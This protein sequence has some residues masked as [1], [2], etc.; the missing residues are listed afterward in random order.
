MGAYEWGIEEI[1]PARADSGGRITQRVVQG[2]TYNYSY[3][4]QGQ[5]ASYTDVE[6]PRKSA[7]YTYDHADRRIAMTVGGGAAD[8]IA[9][10]YA[11]DYRFVYHGDD[12]VAEYVDKPGSLKDY[13]RIYWLMPDIDQRIGF[14][15]IDN[16]GNKDVYYYLTDHQGS[17]LQVVDDDGDVVNQYDYDAFGVINWNNSYEGIENRYKFQGREYDSHAGHY[18]YRYR[19]Y[20]PEWG[21][22][23]SPDM[24]LSNGI[25]GEPNGIGNYLFCNNNPVNWRDPR[26]LYTLNS[27]GSLTFDGHFNLYDS[28]W[29]YDNANTGLLLNYNDFEKRLNGV[30]TIGSYNHQKVLYNSSGMITQLDASVGFSYGTIILDDGTKINGNSLYTA[31]IANSK[32]V[33]NPQYSLQMSD[34][35]LSYK[36]AKNI[37]DVYIKNVCELPYKDFGIVNNEFEH[38]N[39][40]TILNRSKELNLIV[41]KQG[42]K[43]LMNRKS[44]GFSFEFMGQIE[45]WTYT[46]YST[47][48]GKGCYKWCSDSGRELVINKNREIERRDEFLATYNYYTKKGHGRYDMKPYYPW[49][50]TPFDKSTY[51]QKICGPSAGKHW[52]WVDDA[53]GGISWWYVDYL[54]PYFSK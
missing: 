33:N 11:A 19:T 50:N 21:S 25:L 30:K 9:N 5:L 20:I 15:H 28:T 38:W 45:T 10:P 46:E 8:N 17:V 24:N 51:S 43:Y 37:E 32:S 52:R 1:G 44:S 7:T 16:S 49:G 13:K 26:G 23:T 54:H 22:F 40:R 47:Y 14:I 42:L 36:E 3:T 2:R 6:D 34:G 41:E 39:V 29:S 4:S 35:H 27:D 18:Y 31:H 53:A 12:V 48:H